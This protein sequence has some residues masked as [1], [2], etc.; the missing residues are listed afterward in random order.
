M[1]TFK[2]DDKSYLEWA[3]AHPNG[4]VLNV[5]QT[6]TAPQIMLHTARCAHVTSEAHK[7]FVGQNYYK[8]CSLDSAELVA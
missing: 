5:P 3:A 1:Q 4:F 7:N 8:V 6:G 2:D